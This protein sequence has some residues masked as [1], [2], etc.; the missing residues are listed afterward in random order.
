MLIRCRDHAVKF[1]KIVVPQAEL[2][3]REFMKEQGLHE[4][5]IAVLI[6]HCPDTVE[7]ALDIQPSILRI[8]NQEG[9]GAEVL[10]QIV[11]ALEVAVHSGQ[12][13][14]K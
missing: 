7:M 4:F 1:N 9:R 6:N 11:E 13:T 2:G 3:A 8:Q 14:D 5:E 12:N 10:E